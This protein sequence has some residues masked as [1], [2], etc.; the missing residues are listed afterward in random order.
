MNIIFYFPYKE[1]SGVPV[2]FL[3]LAEFFASNFPEASISVVDYP[4]GFMTQ[5]KKQ[6]SRIKFISF[7][8]GNP[9][10]INNGHVIMQAI[11]PYAMRP[12]LQLGEETKVIFWS[13]FPEIFLP[14][15]FPISLLFK[16]NIIKLPTYKKFLHFFWRINFHQLKDFVKYATTNNAL[17]FMDGPNISKTE[18]ILDLNLQEYHFLPITSSGAII[19]STSNVQKR[20][21]QVLNISFIGRLCNFKYRSVELLIK[22]LNRIA[23][24]TETHINFFVIGDGA[25][26][27]YLQNLR[28]DNSY[29]KITFTGTIPKN[30]LDDFLSHNVHINISM[31]TSALES[32]RL[33]IAT[34]LTDYSYLQI[35]PNYKYRWLHETQNFDLGHII[36]SSDYE[37]GNNTLES[38]IHDFKQNPLQYEKFSYEYFIKNHSI[39]SVADGILKVIEKGV[40]SFGS[41]KPEYF[42]KSTV[43]KLY[44]FIKYKL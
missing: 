1:V 6:D 24:K 12:E 5:N 21:L 23:S 22:Q 4:D 37:E 35:S 33:N 39:E 19:S 20:N 27:K 11:L 17:H 32:A 31:G 13:L 8:D 34:I 41:Y 7:L 18:E 38:M 14:K 30:E 2:L 36:C 25:Y 26:T 44:E 28:I 29:L 3:N 42:R 40:P 10:I 43:R 16:F 9:L 15:V